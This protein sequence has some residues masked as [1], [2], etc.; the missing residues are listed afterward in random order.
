M[1]IF[2]VDKKLKAMTKIRVT[3]N[4]E[5]D[6]AHA[7]YGYDG[8]CRNIHGHTYKLSV[9]VRGEPSSDIASPTM[10]MLIDFGSLK[11][12]ITDGIVNVFDHSLI[13]NRSEHLDRQQLLQ[14]EMFKRAHLVDF[15]P[16]VENLT[17]YFAHV[18]APLL[19]PGIE[20]FSLKLHETTNSY[21]EWFADDQ[22]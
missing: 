13:V 22:R 21:A 12:I 9:T 2:V 18:I 10:G 19:P 14:N 6:M 8:L 16:T 1:V 15:Q 7:L 17:I 11:K 4:F 5:F 20:L 3:R